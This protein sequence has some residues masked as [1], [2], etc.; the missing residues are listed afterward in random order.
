MSGNTLIFLLK[1]NK[2]Y[3]LPE[4]R[5]KKPLPIDFL[6]NKGITTGQA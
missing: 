3:S 6:N 4:L 1:T 5:K 2:D